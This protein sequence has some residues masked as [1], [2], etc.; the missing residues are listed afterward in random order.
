MDALL[1]FR[2]HRKPG[3]ITLR[4]STSLFP[5]LAATFNCCRSVKGDRNVPLLNEVENTGTRAIVE[6]KSEVQV[7]AACPYMGAQDVP[8]TRISGCSSSG[9]DGI[10]FRLWNASGTEI[11]EREVNANSRISSSANFPAQWNRLSSFM[12]SDDRYMSSFD[13]PS[14]DQEAAVG[15]EDIIDGDDDMWVDYSLNPQLNLALRQEV[16]QIVTQGIL[17]S[18]QK[19]NSITAAI[20]S[21]HTDVGIDGDL[22][23]TAYLKDHG[24]ESVPSSNRTVPDVSARF[25]SSFLGNMLS[26]LLVT[27][28]KIEATYEH[29]FHLDEKQIFTDRYPLVFRKLRSLLGISDEWYSHQIALPAQERLSEGSSG[30]F[31]FFCGSGEFMVKTISSFESKVLSSILMKYA[32]HLSNNPESMLVR[33]LGLHELKMYNQTFNFVVMKNIFPPS[34]TIN[35]KYDIKGSWVNRSSSGLMPPGTKTFCKHCG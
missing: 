26:N 33:F 12:N 9:A 25:R 21:G 10:A 13:V 5:W 30:A 15:E 2:M 4:F 8:K 32:T 34:A 7:H 20:S 28:E 3:R 19:A 29:S 14:V 17:K 23:R 22:S 18:I 31:M 27:D 6:R 35:L 16:L 1:W 24:E 11:Q